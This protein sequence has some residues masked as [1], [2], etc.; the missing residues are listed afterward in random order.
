MNV[1]FPKWAWWIIG[2]VVV[3]A[4]LWVLRVDMHLGVGG[5]SFTCGLFK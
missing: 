5:F 4:V 2:A 1:N 3:L